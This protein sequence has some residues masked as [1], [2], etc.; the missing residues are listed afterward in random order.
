[1]KSEAEKIW[2]I[3]ALLVSRE[4]A[5][6]PALM[7]S[8]NKSVSTEMHFDPKEKIGKN[9]SLIRTTECILAL[10]LNRSMR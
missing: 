3:D 7:E 4:K 9:N 1:M 10:P 6:G 5:Y 2:A 8:I